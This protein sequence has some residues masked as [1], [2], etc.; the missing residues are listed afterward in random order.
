[1]HKKKGKFRQKKKHATL[2]KNMFV[3]PLPW[4]NSFEWLQLFVNFLISAIPGLVFFKMKSLPRRRGKFS[5][6]SPS[7]NL[8]S[9]S[10]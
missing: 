4:A 8:T 9:R 1:M 5:K 6:S 3:F 2:P 7:E 10:S